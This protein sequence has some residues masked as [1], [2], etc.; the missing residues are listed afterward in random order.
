ME[1]HNKENIMRSFNKAKLLLVAAALL[2]LTVLEANPGFTRQMDMNCMACHNQTM[3]QLNAFGRKFAASGFTMTSGSQS[4]IDGNTI[5]LGL[6][7]ALNAGVLLKARYIKSIPDEGDGEEDVGTDRGS[8]EM[9]KVSK[10]F[11][12]G[13]IA[14]NVGGIGNFSYD[15]FGAKIA[16]TDELGTGYM[17]ISA[18]MDDDFG[19]FSG[20]EY[21]NTGL[22]APLKLFEN[23]RGTNA[24]QATEVGHGPA[25][26]IQA[27]YGGDVLYAMAGGYVPATSQHEGLD[28]GSSGI[29]IARIAVAP[30]FG[31][32][33]V[34]VG[35]YGLSGTAR[36]SDDALDNA[37]ITETSELINITREAY[38]M[39]MQVEGSVAGMNTVFVLNAVF[40]N[41]TELDNHST[42]ANY[43]ELSFSGGD[44]EYK[45][46]YNTAYSAEL[47]VNP[48][49]PLGIKLSYLHYDDK[50]DYRY[51]GAS[52][53]KKINKQDRDDYSLGLDY[54]FRQNVRLAVE[55][56]YSDVRVN[57]KYSNGGTLQSLPDSDNFFVYA[58]IG[59]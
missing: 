36:L 55:Y 8:L 46:G 14:D 18:F 17:G 51:S 44:V 29:G 5:K 54:S 19:P 31:E 56:T 24:A 12:G 11:F 7:S 13:K 37:K 25:T 28:I 6:P 23:R 40:Y 32:W 59:F 35:A 39:D 30:T 21:Y 22:Y 52:Q 3:S 50:Y 49:E 58:M 26:G 1:K 45:A 2:P 27:Y 43:D 33:M 38:G 15:S 41:R 10:L 53:D 20:M 9:Y 34:M 42:G 48:W 57:D 47:Q 16:F 4:M